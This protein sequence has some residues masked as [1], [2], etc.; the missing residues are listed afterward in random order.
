[1]AALKT[2]RENSLSSFRIRRQARHE[3]A[4]AFTHASTVLKFSAMRG[5]TIAPPTSTPPRSAS[6]LTSS[7]APRCLVKVA[8][9]DALM[10]LGHRGD[11]GFHLVVDERRLLPVRRRVDLPPLLR[12]GS[13]E[14]SES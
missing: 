3:L 2:L 12:K 1:V 5:F 8:H 4:I 10:E 14:R 9:D 7:R 11:D 13:T 6:Q